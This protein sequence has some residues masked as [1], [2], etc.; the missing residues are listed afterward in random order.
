MFAISQLSIMSTGVTGVC[1]MMNV[2]Y[3]QQDKTIKCLSGPNYPDSSLLFYSVVGH[4]EPV[5]IINDSWRPWDQPMTVCISDVH[6]YFDAFIAVS[7]GMFI[8]IFIVISN[9]WSFF[10]LELLI[11]QEVIWFLKMSIQ[12]SM[13]YVRFYKTKL[14]PLNC[15]YEMDHLTIT[16]AENSVLFH[17]N[18]TN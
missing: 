2:W 13:S 6:C 4:S 15:D 16:A 14:L 8:I 3:F 10:S 9:I 17:Y 18:A 12:T 1:G 5:I 7:T 11:L